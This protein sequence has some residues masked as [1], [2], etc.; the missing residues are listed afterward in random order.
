MPACS[1]AGRAPL[2]PNWQEPIGDGQK[3]LCPVGCRYFPVRHWSIRQVYGISTQTRNK[4]AQKL[5]TL[6]TQEVRKIV[7]SQVPLTQLTSSLTAVHHQN[8]ETD[9]TAMQLTRP[10]TQSG[11]YQ[12]LRV[13]AGEPVYVSF[14][15][16]RLY[17]FLSPTPRS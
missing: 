1:P 16:C 9:K 5:L 2:F 8:Q 10:Y 14:L 13:L 11:F 6:D 17:R 3:S 4:N 15:F 7:D 12:L